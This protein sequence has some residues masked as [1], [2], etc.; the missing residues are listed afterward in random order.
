[1]RWQFRESVKYVGYLLLV[2]EYKYHLKKKAPQMR[3]FFLDFIVN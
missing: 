1:M 3:C 2:D